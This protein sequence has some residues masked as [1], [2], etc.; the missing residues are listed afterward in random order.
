MIGM[1]ALNEII[2]IKGK[3]ITTLLQNKKFTILSVSEKNIKIRV[4]STG[5]ERIINYEREIYAAYMEL[6][7]KRQLTRIE[8][9]KLFALYNPAFVAA[10]LAQLPRVRYSVKPV[11]TLFID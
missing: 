6:K 1:H 3:T 9:Q 2:K 4:E 11:I 10:I 5:K 8:I 7:R